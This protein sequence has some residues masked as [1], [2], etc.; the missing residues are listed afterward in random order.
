MKKKE[1]VKL[2]AAISITGFIALIWI[3]GCIPVS[4]EITVYSNKIQNEAV[5]ALIS[6]YHSCYYGKN[7]SKIMKMLEKENPDVVMLAGDI[8]DG[9]KRQKNAKNFLDTIGEA[10]PCYYVT[11]NHEFWSEEADTMIEYVESAGITVLRGET[12]TTN[13]NGNEI[14]VCG[15]DDPEV[16]LYDKD[17]MSF[18]SQLSDCREACANG[19]YSILLFHRPERVFNYKDYGF[20][21]V[22]SGHAHGGQW[23]I[24]GILPGVYAPNQGIFPTFTSG[25][26]KF[27]DTILIVSRGLAKGTTPVPRIFNHP[28]IVFVK[29]MPGAN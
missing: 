25:K 13:I 2:I 7:A 4:E 15:I 11:G 23:R 24:P 17:S 22:L 3:I 10:Y 19:R 16:D 18:V 27:D 29:I 5:V 6:D 28:E 26:Y 9:K 20:D 21:L 1:K 14:N 12:V 8:F